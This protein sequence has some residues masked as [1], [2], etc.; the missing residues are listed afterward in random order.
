MQIQKN[1]K[2]RLHDVIKTKQ[3][4]V[5]EP[6]KDVFE[7]EN[8][9]SEYY[10]LCYRVDLYFHD[11]KLVIDV[12][13]FDHNVRDIN[14]ERRRQKK[15]KKNCDCRGIRIDPYEE[16]FNIFRYI[17][18]IHRHIS[19]LNKKLTE[20]STKKSLIDKISKR[21][22]EFELKKNNSVISRALKHFIKKIFPT[23]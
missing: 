22:L 20:E 14:Y 13:E 7:G 18:E 11:Y 15:K 9:Q 12:D 17:N 3:Q 6:I 10:I 8:V 1:F 21:L 19:E 4:P 23:V 5:L 16:N 2:F